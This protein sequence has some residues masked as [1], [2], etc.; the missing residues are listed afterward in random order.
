[1]NSTTKQAQ[2][3]PQQLASKTQEKHRN[4]T[5]R[6]KM[7]R[8]RQRAWKEHHSMDMSSLREARKWTSLS[9]ISKRYWK[10][11]IAL[12]MAGRTW[13]HV[14]GNPS[15]NH[16]HSLTCEDYKVHRAWEFKWGRVFKVLWAEPQDHIVTSVRTFVK[17]SPSFP[18]TRRF[19]VITQ[20]EGH[21]I[22]LYILLIIEPN[23]R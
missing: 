7:K 16:N 22:C 18:E 13:N 8:Y 20:M 10:E 17:G 21:S 3:S 15:Q 12:M 14:K 23:T 2:M 9:T 1:M 5:A 4:S 19:V 6:R 11:A